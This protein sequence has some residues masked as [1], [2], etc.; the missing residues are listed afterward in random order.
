MPKFGNNR[1]TTDMKIWLITDTHFNHREKMKLYCNRPDDYED[2]LAKGMFSLGSEDL[3]I[4]LGDVCI[5]EELKIHNEIIERMACRKILVRGNHDNKSDNWYLTHG[6]DFVCFKFQAKYYGKTIMFSHMPQVYSKEI[7]LLF[8]AGSYDINIHGHFHNMNNKLMDEDWEKQN[9][10]YV[11]KH[12][13]SPVN[14]RSRLLAVEYT[15][16]QPIALQDFLG[17]GA[18][19]KRKL[20]GPVKFRRYAQSD[21]KVNDLRSLS[22]ESK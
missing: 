8:G 1:Y 22:D 18:S 16:Y 15:N 12:D 17:I 3:L 13:I 10:E 6:W 20:V 7:D 9:A 11:S 14:S 2:R 21:I 5:G 4:H 19:K